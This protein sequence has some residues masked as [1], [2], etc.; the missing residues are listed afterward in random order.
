MADVISHSQNLQE[1]KPGE[2][3]GN[4]SDTK[5]YLDY[6]FFFSCLTE[7]CCLAAVED[8]Y[9]GFLLLANNLPNKEVP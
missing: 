1:M 8:V 4:S 5:R 6:V 2:E 9:F 7:V 3:G